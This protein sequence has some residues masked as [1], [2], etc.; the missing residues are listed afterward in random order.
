VRGREGQGRA[1]EEKEG[2]G[3]NDLMHSLS[4]IPGYTTAPVDRIPEKFL[5]LI[6]DLAQSDELG[7]KRYSSPCIG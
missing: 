2:E 4:Q 1:E 6:C 5:N 3:K 7:V